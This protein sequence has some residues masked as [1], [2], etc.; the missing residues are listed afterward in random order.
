MF[1]HE[2]GQPVVYVYEIHV[3]KRVR[4]CG[5]G[6]HLLGM[7]EDMGR[8]VGVNKSMLTVFR[9]NQKTIDWY[10]HLGYV[11]DEYSPAD[12]VLRGGKIKQSD[13]LILSKNLYKGSG[14]HHQSPN[15][16]S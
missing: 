5:L 16:K 15:A 10:H 4:G 12:K 11:V 1:T 7:V 9:S 2:D 13:Y 6:K 14:G 8:S 3:S